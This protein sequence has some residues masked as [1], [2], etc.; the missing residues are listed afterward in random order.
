[1]IPQLCLDVRLCQKFLDIVHHILVL[2]LECESWNVDEHDPLAIELKLVGRLDCAGPPIPNVYANSQTR[3]TSSVDELQFQSLE[4]GNRSYRLSYLP[5]FSQ[6]STTLSHYTQRLAISNAIREID[7][8]R[9]KRRR[10]SL[11][12]DRVFGC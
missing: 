1:M 10:A 3:T 2:L 11:F 9:D 5:W 4:S 12:R 8:V 6:I 7:H